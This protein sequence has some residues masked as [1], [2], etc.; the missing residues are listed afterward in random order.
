MSF[1]LIEEGSEAEKSLVLNGA[2]PFKIVD[3]TSEDKHI[4]ASLQPGNQP[5]QVIKL[6]YK[7]DQPRAVNGM[8]TIYTDVEGGMETQVVYNGK[9]VPKPQEE[10]KPE[11]KPSVAESKPAESKPAEDKPAESKPA[12]NQPVVSTPAEKPAQAAETPAESK[13]ANTL[14]GDE[15]TD[16]NNLTEV[17]DSTPAEET[18]APKTEAPATVETAPAPATE[19]QAPA[20]DAKQPATDASESIAVPAESAPQS[21][22]AEEAKAGTEGDIGLDI[23]VETP[24]VKGRNLL[25]KK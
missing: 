19:T 20:T 17:L 1:G 5:V 3:I 6:R 13:P 21:P 7:A 15:V 12:E 11:P 9:I 24:K 4:S 18:P 8:I 22:A 16:I 25:K 14:P 23:P 2:A 10:K